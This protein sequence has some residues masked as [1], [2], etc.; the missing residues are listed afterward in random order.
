[1]GC[2]GTIE[3]PRWG[4]CPEEPDPHLIANT[5]T[6]SLGILAF[7]TPISFSS[8]RPT[9]PVC[10][11]QFYRTMTTEVYSY[12]DNDVNQPRL[13]GRSTI[14]MNPPNGLQTTSEGASAATLGAPIAGSDFIQQVLEESDTMWHIGAYQNDPRLEGSIVSSQKLMLSGPFDPMD[15][16]PALMSALGTHFNKWEGEFPLG[17]WIAAYDRNNE[18]FSGHYRDAHAGVDFFG[19]NPEH[20]CGMDAYCLQTAQVDAHRAAGVY[21]NY[22]EPASRYYMNPPYG[23]FSR[24]WRRVVW[25][26]VRVPGTRLFEWQRDNI[27]RWDVDGCTVVRATDCPRPIATRCIEF[28]EDRTGEG[29]RVTH[30][31]PDIANSYGRTIRGNCL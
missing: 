25:D 9:G 24:I 4:C 10:P 15:Y 30:E 7:A 6:A 28:R 20:V 29:N 11:R 5:W 27:S 14:T 18:V 1:M 19:P 17:E 31:P 2:E 13:Q 26:F 21:T 16:W 12:D 8:P 3:R 23:A 22:P